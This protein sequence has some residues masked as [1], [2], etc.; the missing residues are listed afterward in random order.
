MIQK[1]RSRNRNLKGKTTARD[2]ETKKG[3][4]SRRILQQLVTW[5]SLVEGSG[6]RKKNNFRA[7]G[8]VD[9][10]SPPS[11]S[12]SK[13]KVQKSGALTAEQALLVK[14]WRFGR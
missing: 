4:N 7:K 2:Q 5:L 10:I 13:V 11:S 14:Q 6:G 9:R 1:R 8:A 3:V 12:E